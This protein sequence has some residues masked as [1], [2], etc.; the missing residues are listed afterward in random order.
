VD[1]SLYSVFTSTYTTQLTATVQTTTLT[2]T[3]QSTFTSAIGKAAV[4]A[5]SSVSSSGS[6]ASAETTTTAAG[7]KSKAQ[8]AVTLSTGILVVIIVGPLLA[9]ALSL[10]I[11]LVLRRKRTA[12]QG[13]SIRLNSAGNH[14]PPNGPVGADQVHP[15][16][17]D[18]NEVS[19]PRKEF[20]AY[21]SP[22]IDSHEI[23]DR[24]ATLRGEKAQ[25]GFGE[26][27][28]QA[29]ELGVQDHERVWSPAP[30]YREFA[31]PVELDGTSS[32]DLPRRG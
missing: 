28:P 25:Q 16:E 31:M 11:F 5:T 14:P 2:S 13:D 4:S 26:K 8:K 22:K 17:V 23:D 20:Y 15:Y 18:V 9:I 27:M 29:T 10:G 1:P 24:T 7:S 30:T 6:V 21:K 3:F 12:R 19:G 32:V